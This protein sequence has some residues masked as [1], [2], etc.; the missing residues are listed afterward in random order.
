MR[1]WR[2]AGKVG[3]LN[4]QRGMVRRI[5]CQGTK[6]RRIKNNQ[7]APPTS[8]KRLLPRARQKRSQPQKIAKEK[9]PLLVSL[10]SFCSFYLRAP[11]SFRFGFIF[12]VFVVLCRW[13]VCCCASLCQRYSSSIQLT[14][15]LCSSNS[16]DNDEL[17]TTS[18]SNFVLY[19]FLLLLLWLP[20]SFHV[21]PSLRCFGK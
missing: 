21:R 4:S 19:F 10:F 5:K 1:W 3:L 14:L 12:F 18:G 17:N 2:S 6:T 15:C 11:H 8:K 7:C 20:L 16:K 13:C 9:P